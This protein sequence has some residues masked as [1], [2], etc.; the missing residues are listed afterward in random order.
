MENYIRD[1]TLI[2]FLLYLSDLFAVP[3]YLGLSI[4]TMPLC[5]MSVP[6]KKEVMLKLQSKLLH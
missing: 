5:A 6:L 1:E 2:L 3:F 4:V